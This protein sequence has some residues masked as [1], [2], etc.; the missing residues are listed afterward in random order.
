[1][2]TKRAV[3]KPAK[4][5]KVEKPKLTAKKPVAKARAGRESECR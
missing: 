1:M 3:S 4:A 2:P 5:K